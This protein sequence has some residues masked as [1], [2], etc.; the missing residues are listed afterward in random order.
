M[1]LCQQ[2]TGTDRLTCSSESF[3]QFKLFGSGKKSCKNNLTLQHSHDV[4]PGLADGYSRDEEHTSSIDAQGLT[5]SIAI[6]DNTPIRTW[7]YFTRYGNSVNQWS[8][9]C[10]QVFSAYRVWQSITT[11]ASSFL[12]S[13]RQRQTVSHNIP[14]TSCLHHNI[15]C[16]FCCTCS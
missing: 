11:M 3:E 9:G 1:P 10:I 6:E 12:Q 15:A 2:S 13:A 14:I 8:I 5:S 7:T 16:G 4:L